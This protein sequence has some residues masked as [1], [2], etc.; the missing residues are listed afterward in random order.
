MNKIL[1]IA[2]HPDDETLGCG[3][4]IFHHKN[5]GDQNYLLSL[6]SMKKEFGWST[7]KILNRDKEIKKINDFYAFKD[8]F[9]L[10]YPP[11]KVDNIHKSEIIEK[12]SN[13][14]KKIKPNI[15]YIPFINDIHTDHQIIAE[16]INACLKWFRYP[17]LKK[18]LYYETLSETNFNFSS[19]RK[20]NPNVYINITPYIHKKNSAMKIYKSEIKKHPFPRSKESIT[21]LAI[22]RGSECG[23]KYAEAFELILEYN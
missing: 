19:D 2:P 22:L 16:C 14:F 17:Y 1:Y 21:S 12:I 5:K 15:V 10:N 8:I 18:A 11:S 7:N 13:I 6:T 23:C 4:T 3:G 20:F 9:Y